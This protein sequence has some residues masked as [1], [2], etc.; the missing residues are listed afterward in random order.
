MNVARPRALKRH[1]N[2]GSPDHPSASQLRQRMHGQNLV[3][4][5][6]SWHHRVAKPAR[7]HAAPSSSQLL[8]RDRAGASLI[9]HATSPRA[10][11]PQDACSMLGAAAIGTARLSRDR[12][13]RVLQATVLR[14]RRYRGDRAPLAVV[15]V[16]VGTNDHQPRVPP[17]VLRACGDRLRARL[18][19]CRASASRRRASEMTRFLRCR[20]RTV[21]SQPVRRTS[22]K[23]YRRLDDL[24]GA[25]AQRHANLADVV[26]S[27]RQTRLSLRAMLPDGS[28]SSAVE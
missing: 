5:R 4:A 7:Y 18:R 13:N 12:V 20:G 27:G 10:D 28:T 24:A 19:G 9:R 1:V 15:L 8:G 6:I 21:R 16:M 14:L 25:L 11:R 23:G 2:V 26:R 22:M 17:R 3:C